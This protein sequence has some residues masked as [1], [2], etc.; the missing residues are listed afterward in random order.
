MQVE[1]LGP[2]GKVHYRRPHD[3]PDVWEALKTPGYSVHGENPADCVRLLAYLVAKGFNFKPTAPPCAFPPT[4]ARID[5]D[6]P[7][8]A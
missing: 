3:H 7:A 6:N 5:P 8:G 2:D 4:E 1:I